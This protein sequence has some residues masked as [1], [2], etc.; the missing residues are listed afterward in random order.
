MFKPQRD[1]KPREG[2]QLF[3]LQS[4]VRPRVWLIDLEGLMGLL[5]FEVFL[6]QMQMAE[7]GK[8]GAQAV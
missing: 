5:S 3:L 1:D 7:E 6:T 8:T 4:S 2:R